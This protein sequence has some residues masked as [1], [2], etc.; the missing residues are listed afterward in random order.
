M[1]VSDV[2]AAIPPELRQILARAQEDGT[3]AGLLNELSGESSAIDDSEFELLSE[4]P[5]SMTDASK[6]RLVDN[7]E[8]KS[9]ECIQRPVTPKPIRSIE[10]YGQELPKGI[11][12]IEQWGQTILSA[13]KFAKENMSYD[14][15]FKSKSENHMSYVTWMYSQRHRSDFTPL[16]A[17]F[18]RY[19]NVKS[20]ALS[21]D[22]TCFEGSHVARKF[23]K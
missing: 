5:I 6:R 14:E 22:K 12:S 23:K 1:S 9:A 11:H 10:A 13:G 17:D 18:A 21:S 16:L 2:R 19:V 4:A 3:L 7:V 15:V 20:M 8:Q